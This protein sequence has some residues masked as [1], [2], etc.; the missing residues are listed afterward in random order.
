MGSERLLRS[1]GTQE[2]ALLR[3]TTASHPPDASVSHLA[4]AIFE[5]W[6]PN[7]A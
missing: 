5:L 6:Q 3:L 4:E 1:G 2:T 7:D